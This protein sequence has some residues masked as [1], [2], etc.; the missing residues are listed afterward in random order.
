[1]CVCVCTYTL[2]GTVVKNL[3]ANAEGIGNSGLIPGF[4]RSPGG[5]NGNPFQYSCLENFMDSRVANSWK[6]LN[7]DICNVIHTHK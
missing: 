6:Q 7:P 4:G 1:M 2:A 5:G 3:L